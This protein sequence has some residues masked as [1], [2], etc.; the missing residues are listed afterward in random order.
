MRDYTLENLTLPILR[1]AR[2]FIQQG[3]IQD[4]LACDIHKKDV[5]IYDPD[6]THYCLLGSVL[7]ATHHVQISHGWR[8]PDLTNMS[9]L[10]TALGAIRRCQAAIHTLHPTYDAPE[11]QA[12]HA[13]LPLF[14]LQRVL[15]DWND[16]PE[17][18]QA[19]VIA[20]LDRALA[21]EESA[22]EE[23][24]ATALGKQQLS[25]LGKH[26]ERMADSTACMPATRS[27]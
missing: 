7:Q 17:R 24:P 4:S 13:L 12:H 16:R 9:I 22:D 14:V 20:L 8:A 1:Q 6:A 3:W 18:T 10:E 23:D 19:E 11:Q 15:S 21:D 27:L 26:L 25:P 2:D 5:A